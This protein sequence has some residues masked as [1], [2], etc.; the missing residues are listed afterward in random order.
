MLAVGVM[1][2][3]VHAEHSRH[4][5]V[6]V[7]HRRDERPIAKADDRFCLDRV[8]KQLCLVGRE[9]RRLAGL[10][11][12]DNREVFG[13]LRLGRERAGHRRA[14]VFEG[15]S[16]ADAGSLAQMLQF[17]E[18]RFGCRVKK[19]FAGQGSK[20]D[21]GTITELVSACRTDPYQSVS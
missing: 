21:R 15:D 8:E 12:L 3:D 14:P 1:V 6:A 7:D 20:K 13:F 17:L 19:L 9:N 5:S 16:P 10:V 11:P 4:A 2:F 18:E